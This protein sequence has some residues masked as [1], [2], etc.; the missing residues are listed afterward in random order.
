MTL[1]SEG[2]EG[3]GSRSVTWKL[4]CR[5]F[6]SP[7]LFFFLTVSRGRFF[8]FFYFYLYSIIYFSR[9]SRVLVQLS[10]IHP[11]QLNCSACLHTQCDVLLCDYRGR[12]REKGKRKEPGRG[13]ERV[14]TSYSAGLHLM[15]TTTILFFSLSLSFP[16]CFS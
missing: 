13:A 11:V 1:G 6:L 3:A 8:F 2:D 16:K 7:T 15:P 5:F 14:R 10:S 9:A 4:R 12:E